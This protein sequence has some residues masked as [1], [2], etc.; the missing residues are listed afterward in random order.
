[1]NNL[2]NIKVDSRGLWSRD[3]LALRLT[4][5]TDQSH[6]QSVVSDKL[7]EE[8]FS[9][10][11]LDTFGCEEKLETI[12]LIMLDIEGGEHEALRGAETYLTL[13]VEKAPALIFEVHRSYVDWSDGLHKVDVV[14][15]LES[16][17][18]KVWAI[19]DFQGN[20]P[21]KGRPIELVLP[22]EAHLEGPAHGFNLVAVKNPELLAGP[23][24][25][26]RSGVSPK[27]LRHRD[28]KMH[29]PLED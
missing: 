3:D 6:A 19:R 8:S 20:W 12:D 7:D 27:Y 29:A 22:Q 10:I 1:M 25:R 13:P 18:Y 2:N 9:A 17:G 15:Y 24:F 21:M 11:T 23:E 28:P 26:V 14:R 4:D 5:N 16:L